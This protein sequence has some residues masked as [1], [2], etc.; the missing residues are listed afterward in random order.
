MIEPVRVECPYCG[1]P[2]ETLADCSAGGQCYVE[3]CPVCCRPIEFTLT[4][5][6][7]GGFAGLAARRDDE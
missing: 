1:A 6:W 3:D 4:V 2:F 7:D 5:D